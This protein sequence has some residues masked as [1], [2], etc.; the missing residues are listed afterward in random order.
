MN[1]DRANRSFLASAATAVLLGSLVAWGG[2]AGVLEPMIRLRRATST[3]VASAILA[4]V[5]TMLCVSV[6]VAGA[7]LGLRTLVRQFVASRR[8]SR[9]VRALSAPLSADLITAAASAELAGRVVFVDSAAPFSYVYG[10]LVPRVVVSRGLLSALSARQLQAV[11]AHE[12]YHVV[13]LDPLKLTIIRIIRSA[14]F[15]LPALDTLHRRYLTDRELAADRSAIAACGRATLAAALHRVVDD[16]DGTSVDLRAAIADSGSL[17]ARIRHLETG[18][19][20]RLEAVDHTRLTR[21]FVAVAGLAAAFL[22]SVWTLGGPAT[23]RQATGTGLGATLLLNTVICAAPFVFIGLLG[24]AAT[25]LRARSPLL[26]RRRA[27]FARTRRLPGAD[28]HQ[29]DHRSGETS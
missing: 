22:A 7:A 21:S 18:Q 2:L 11:L 24:Y 15:M 20:P 16:P 13:N 5:P 9:R 23:V 26:P 4:G 19:H 8:L 14:L 3:G 6:A 10:A 25:A 27:R 29:S 28:A 12:R 1:F 17:A